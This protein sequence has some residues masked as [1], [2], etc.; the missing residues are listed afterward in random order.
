MSSNQ[1]AKSPILNSQEGTVARF[2]RQLLI[3]IILKVIE[4]VFTAY[5]NQVQT[6]CVSAQASQPD[7]KFSTL[8][9][10]NHRVHKAG[11]RRVYATDSAEGEEEEEE[12]RADDTE[13]EPINTTPRLESFV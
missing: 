7:S 5:L 2:L 10:H 11:R 13:Y 4:L 3:L 8:H 9:R 1:P 6:D 12:Q